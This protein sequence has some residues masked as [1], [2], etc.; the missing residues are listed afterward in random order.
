MSLICQDFNKLKKELCF[1]GNT[2]QN[3][4]ILVKH[5]SFNQSYKLDYF[6]MK[7]SKLELWEYF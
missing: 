4:N 5:L 1:G 7:F 6:M 2:Y 3:L